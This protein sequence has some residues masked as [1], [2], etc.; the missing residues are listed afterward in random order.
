MTKLQ[1]QLL[2]NRESR[3]Y[4]GFNISFLIDNELNEHKI[5]K[6]IC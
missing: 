6:Q 2:N 1:D 3:F 5:L 4:N